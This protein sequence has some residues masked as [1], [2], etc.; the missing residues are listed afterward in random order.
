VKPGSDLAIDF[1]TPKQQ[2][3]TISGKVVDPNPVAAANG[4]VPAATLS[5]AFQTLTGDSGT[6]T[7]GQ[8]YDS[9]TGTFT[10]RDVQPGSYILQAAVPPSSARMPVEVTNADIE[11]LNV[12]IDSGV[13]VNGRFVVESGDMPA[14]ANLRVTMRIMSNGAQNF[15]GY[16]PSALPAADGTFTMTGVLPGQYRVFVQPPP[17][18]DFYVKE[19]RYDREEAL[20]NPVD[21]SRRNSDSATMEILLSRAV[22]QVD[23][24]VVDERGQAVPGV[25]AVLVPDNNRARFELFKTATTDQTGRFTMRGVAPGDY[26]LFAWE[27]LENY[28]YFD[29]EVLRRAEPLGKA[30]RV[31]E[32]LKLNVETKIIP[33]Q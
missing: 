20:N 26:K 19:L 14:A 32:A 24:V 23:G 6:F 25:Q 29:P 3:Y 16:S 31:G 2:L 15:I 1:V 22:G 10:M 4:V 5:L 17:S 28:G 12:V 7:M 13:T 9:A 30:V 27:G 33:A 11:N 18:Q 8:A 21:V